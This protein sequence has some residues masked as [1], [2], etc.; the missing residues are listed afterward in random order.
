VG[1]NV[2]GDLV[3]RVG[4]AGVEG[5]RSLPVDVLDVGPEF[6]QAL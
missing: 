1:E 3:F 4:N 5:C 2:L 6:N